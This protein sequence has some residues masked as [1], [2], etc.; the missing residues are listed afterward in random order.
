[1]T[2]TQ[3]PSDPSRP[4]P[5]DPPGVTPS[6]TSGTEVRSDPSRGAYLVLR[7]AFVVA[8]VV[9]GL[10]KFTNWLVDW[11]Q[12]LAP[13]VADL[14]P[15]APQQ[16]MYAVGVVEVLAGILVALHPRLGAAVV[17]AWLGGIIVNLTLVGGFLDVALRD[18]GLLLAAVAL[19]RLAVHHDPLPLAW[20][21][22]RS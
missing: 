5:Y 2:A 7:T 12:Y 18:L 22:R 19:Q 10:D 20:P 3:S 15:L 4:A 16:A 21:L 11:T 14:L 1:M 8:P 17:A 6:T 9:F 13:T